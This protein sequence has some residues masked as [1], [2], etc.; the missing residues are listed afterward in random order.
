[1]RRI[2]VCLLAAAAAAPALAQADPPR[3]TEYQ[4]A[5]EV[6]ARYPDVPIGLTA[7]ALAPG[8]AALTSQ[9][10]MLAFL[11]GLKA[12]NP[13]VALGSLGR[14]IEGRDVPVLVFTAEGLEDAAAIRA[15]GRPIVW[16]IGQQHG[17]EPAGGEAMLAVAHAL[18]EGELKPLLDRVTVVVAPRANPDGAAANMRVTANGLDPNRDHLLLTLPEIRA[19]HARMVDLPPDMV[20]DHHEF[21]VAGSW[22]QKFGALQKSDAMLL[23]ATHPE[24]PAGVTDFARDAVLPAME[25]LLRGHG[26]STYAYHTATG[27]SDDRTVSI[28][29][30]APGISRN[31]FGLK[32]ALSFLVETRG[33]G[34]GLQG[35]QRRV[36]THYLSARAVL[37]L[38]AARGPEIR[39][40]VAGARGGLAGSRDPLVVAHRIAT[41][42]ETIPLVDPKTGADRPVAVNLRDSRQATPTATR[43]RPA[44]YLLQ[45][46]AAPALDALRLRGAVVCPLAGGEPVAAE[47]FRVKAR[48]GP[49]NRESINPEGAVEVAIEARAVRPEPEAAFVPMAQPL[50]AVIAA[51]LEPD[52]PGSHVGVGLVPVSEAGEPPIYRLAA[53][54]ALAPGGPPGCDKE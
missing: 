24:T 1:M 42:K 4:Q 7:P 43:P 11:S 15:L 6:L 37:E 29:G 13:A 47:A 28:G 26:L 45:P 9:D 27:R 21:Q 46:A 50:S 2:A 3:G 19:I 34:V 23:S 49:V 36:A 54:P 22:L 40:L 38:A 12:R 44:G 32:G 5:P 16:L 51:A 20:V 39:A 30:N 8:R 18:A 48:P 17:N 52:S 33:I 41:V 53:R 10:E 35:Y 25:G 14:S 31:L